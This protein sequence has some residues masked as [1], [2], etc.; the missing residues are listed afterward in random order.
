MKATNLQTL[1]F[2]LLFLAAFAV[3]AT[4]IT[5]SS[6]PNRVAQ[7]TNVQSAID[8]ATDGDTLLIYGSP[9]SY[10]DIVINQKS[11]VLIGEG[12]NSNLSLITSFGTVGIGR[13][14]SNNSA[15]GTTLLGLRISNLS[16]NANWS[17]SDNSTR[18]L[19][20]ID[21]LR[22]EITDINIAPGSFI[23]HT[24]SDLN[25]INCL[26]NDDIELGR[27]FGVSGS[28]TWAWHTANI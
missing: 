11:L 14:D 27:A 8:D 16:I 17:G 7:Y 21:V 23:V 3:Q 12:Y 26:I 15:N 6:D 5:V 13:F 2:S 25:F 18:T 19:Q 9:S 4:Q 1:L 10:G 28:T 22:C 24:I 20:N